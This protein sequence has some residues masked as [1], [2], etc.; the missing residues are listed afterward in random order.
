MNKL[1]LW[2]P[3]SRPSYILMDENGSVVE[4]G[5]ELTD[6]EVYCDFC[7]ADI[8]LRPVPVVCGSALCLDCLKAEPD[9]KAQVT[10]TLMRL[11]EQQREEKSR[12]V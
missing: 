12:I 4:E 6:K 8:P 7:N 1:E 9:L 3:V 10:P 2:M 5:P 11:W